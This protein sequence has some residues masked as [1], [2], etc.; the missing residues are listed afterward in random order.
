MPR[1]T[2]GFTSFTRGVLS[3]LALART[4]Y[5]GYFDGASILKNFLVRIQG[6]ISRRPGTMFVSMSKSGSSI[7]AIP[8]EFS[9]EQAYVLEFGNHYM[10]VYKDKGQV[11][12]APGVPYEI[13]TP[14]SSV[15]IWDLQYTQSADT[16]YITHPDHP[17]YTLT[18]IDHTA[19]IMSGVSTEYGPALDTPA[20]P[21]TLTASNTAVGTRTIT[22]S[23]S[24]FDALHIGSCWRWDMS[25]TSGYFVI[26]GFTSATAVTAEVKHALNNATSTTWGEAAWS[27]YNG[28]PY[29]AKFHEERLFFGGNDNKPTTIWGSMIGQYK[30]FFTGEDSSHGLA[31]ET[32]NLNAIRWMESTD[33]L[34]IGTTGGV[35]KVEGANGGPLTYESTC[36]TQSRKGS[37]D[38]M[39]EIVGESILYVS[40]SGRKVHELAYSLERDGYVAPNRTVVAE[41]VTRSK[42]VDIAYQSEPDSILWCV[43]GNGKLAAF[44]YEPDEKIL[45]WSG[46]HETEGYFRSVCVIPGSEEDEVWFTVERNGGWMMEYMTTTHWDSIYDCF[47]VDS[48][49]SRTGAGTTTLSILGLDH[50]SGCTVD[51]L[52]DGTV[53]PRRVVNASG[54][55]SLE[56]SGTTIHAGL[57]YTSIY[58]SV[59][60]EGG[61]NEGTAVGKI[62]RI[63]K[64]ALRLH[65]T[66]GG[67]IGF[68]DAMLTD[69][70]Y[71]QEGV[72]LYDRPTD[73]FSGDKILPF[74]SGY[75]SEAYVEVVQDK[76]LPMTILAVLPTYVVR[77]R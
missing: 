7:R 62:K 51:I 22:S 70:P 54:G 23:T 71:R 44:T 31:L 74:K 13:V 12:S 16:V 50:L 5:Q 46:P 36:K 19:W 10:R 39:A 61:S 67:K 29:C 34:I 32:Q 11:E 49:L 64:L 45:A 4:D 38:I 37:A 28:W 42:V 1:I 40:R 35:L 30:N 25:G 3:P 18:R 24:L 48:G 57:P 8:F 14:Y 27:D 53:H 76:P 33:D 6:P 60:L 2:Q 47:F 75:G 66:V 56:Y 77:D 20:N 17:P 72:S 69:I 73:P 9:T 55:V 63:T 15:E 52:V 59:N 43:L 26:T 58:R 65:N 21:P 41:H 68:D